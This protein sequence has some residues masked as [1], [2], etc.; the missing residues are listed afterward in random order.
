MRGYTPFIAAPG[1]LQSQYRAWPRSPVLGCVLRQCC[2]LVVLSFATNAA[3]GRSP[4]P[5]GSTLLPFRFLP[6]G[7]TA[8]SS[9]LDVSYS[10]GVHLGYV[11]RAGLAVQLW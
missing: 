2:M 7:D 10:H 4:F 1:A 6:G 9:A 11:E 5:L 8:V 3:A